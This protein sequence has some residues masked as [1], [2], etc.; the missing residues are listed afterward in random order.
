M[1]LHLSRVLRVEFY[2]HVYKA[3]LYA[4]PADWKTSTINRST[5]F[6][7]SSTPCVCSVVSSTLPQF[8]SIYL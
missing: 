2:L 5:P 1:V 8:A 6:E 4:F 3:R 7:Y